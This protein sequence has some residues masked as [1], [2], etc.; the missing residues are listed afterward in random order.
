MVHTLK[1][2]PAV[3]YRSKAGNELVRNWLNGRE[4]NEQDRQIIGKDVAKAE[5]GWPIG[6]PTCEPLSGGLHVIRSHLPN[7]RITRVIFTIEGG[8][9]VLLHGFVK[10][11][12]DGIKTPQHE[13]DV[14]ADRRR[15]LLVRT[16][17]K[18]DTKK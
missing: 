9:M 1:K 8:F 13:I 5:Y 3:F 4:L 11:A 10:K 16:A 14:A 12:T 2:L 7:N 15:D 6:M 18:K 17:K